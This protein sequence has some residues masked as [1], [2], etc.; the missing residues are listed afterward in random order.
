MTDDASPSPSPFRHFP[1]VQLAFCLACLTMTAWTWMRHSY[2]WDVTPQDLLD[3]NPPLAAGGW[4]GFYVRL[5]GVAA[6][7]FG[8]GNGVMHIGIDQPYSVDGK[9]VTFSAKHP[10]A[11]V[12]PSVNKRVG[13]MVADV[14]G[15]ESPLWSG[16]P[17]AG[18]VVP[19]H[20]MPTVDMR[21][22][23]F[24]GASIAGIVVGAM[25]CLILGLYLRRWLVERRRLG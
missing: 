25:G 4:E 19:S 17:S 8:N 7:G 18:R 23:R 15:E 2:A 11:M 5:H 13:A 6:I 16:G 9:Q 3:S 10:V 12:D 24:T 22:H 1:C 14:Q 20:S 21:S